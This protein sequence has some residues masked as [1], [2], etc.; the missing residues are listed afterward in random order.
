MVKWRKIAIILASF[1]IIFGASTA[2]AATQRFGDEINYA[3][4]K[5]IFQIRYEGYIQFKPNHYFQG[6]Y[7]KRAYFNYLRDGKSVSGGRVYTA[8]APTKNNVVYSASKSVWD[9]LNPFAPKT[10]FKYG[11]IKF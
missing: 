8:T 6:G 2:S 3:Q 11:W 1:A 7:V 9:S 5:E 10:E 4:N